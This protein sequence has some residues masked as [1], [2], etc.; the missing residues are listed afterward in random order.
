MILEDLANKWNVKYCISIG[1]VAVKFHDCSEYS[2]S[3]LDDGRINDDDIYDH[4]NVLLQQV[5][6]IKKNFVAFE[7]IPSFIEVKIALK[8]LQNYPNVK[9]F[10]TVVATVSL[11]TLT[12]TYV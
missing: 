8:V 11:P 10:L 3:Y 6:K 5:Q 2:A 9:C 12:I 4:Y 7:T 1:P